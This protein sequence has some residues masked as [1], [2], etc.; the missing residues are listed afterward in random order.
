[1]STI[2]KS[3]GSLVAHDFPDLIQALH[4]YGWS[5]TLTLTHG[6]IGKSVVVEGGRLVFASSSGADDRLGEL[7]LRQ[8][9]VGL[10]QLLDAGRAVVPGKRLGT[11][12]VENGVLDAKE[13]V[14][15]V[16]QHSQEII[17]SLFQWTEGRYRLQE[18]PPATS[19]AITLKMS[20][21]SIILE[22]IRRIDSWG[23]IDRGCGGIEAQYLRTDD[24]E[25][26]TADMNLSFEKLS[27]LTT[28]NGIRSVGQICEESSLPDFEICRCLWAFRVIGAVERL[29]AEGTSHEASVE[30]DG[31]TDMLASEVS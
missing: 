24:Y 21:A 25:A 31:L 14:R 20:T 19:E 26:R 15:T 12:L 1:V 22:G 30:D 11:I 5:G 3:E 7:L 9:R 29:E 17:Y 18:G 13:L 16:V 10:R 6:G 2:P 23:R 8:G 4:A 28:L 27:L